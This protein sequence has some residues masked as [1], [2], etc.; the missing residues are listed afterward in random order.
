MLKQGRG[1]DPT[2]Y[3]FDN[4][5]SVETFTNVANGQT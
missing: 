5:S 3:A 2:P 4:Y 1:G